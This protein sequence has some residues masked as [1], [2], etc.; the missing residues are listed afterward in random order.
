MH[1]S[2]IRTG[3]SLTVCWSLLPRGVYLVLGGVLSPGG[4]YLV[5]GGIL[6]LRE[7]LSPGGLLLGGVCSGGAVCLLGGLCVCSGGC[8]FW[9]LALGGGSGESAPRGGRGVSTPGRGVSQHALRQTPPCG[10]NHRHL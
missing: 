1:S 8:L 4:V 9:G 10:Q 2:R 5:P 6:S 7:V 3:R